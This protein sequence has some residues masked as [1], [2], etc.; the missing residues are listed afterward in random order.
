MTRK[1]LFMMIALFLVVGLALILSVDTAMAQKEPP[2]PPP[3]GTGCS[4]GFYKNHPEVWVNICCST[5]SDPTCGELNTALTCKGS[6]A[7][8]FIGKSQPP[9]GSSLDSGSS[10]LFHDSKTDGSTREPA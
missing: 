6:D 1:S 3:K 4:P 8:S 5:A 2:P 7:R 10:C 9:R